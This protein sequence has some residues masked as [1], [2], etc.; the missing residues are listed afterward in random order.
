[1]STGEFMVNPA[2]RYVRRAA[3]LAGGAGL[4]DGQLLARFIAHRD[5]AAFEMLVRRHG[6]MV[7]GVCRRILR[8]GPDTDDAFQATFLVL[9]RKAAAIADRAKL[10]NW[11]YG[12]A[13]RTA[14]KARALALRRRSREVPMANL[15]DA[16]AATPE[17]GWADWLPVLDRELA[18]LP[19]KYRIA[20]VLCDLEGRTQKAA[21][22]Q[23]G[24]PEGTVSSRLS[25]ARAMLAARLTRYK[26]PITAGLLAAAL[27]EVAATRVRAALVGTTVRSAVAVAGGSAATGVMISAQV[28]ALTEGVMKAMLLSKLKIAIGAPVAMILGIAI[29][30]VGADVVRGGRPGAV[31]APAPAA[32]PA[33]AAS[34]QVRWEYKTVTR[35]ELEDLAPEDAKDRLLSGL[36]ALGDEGWELTAIDTSAGAVARQIKFAGGG[37]GF[38]GA[39]AQPGA[40]APGNAGGP[41]GAVVNPIGNGAM[42]T[43]NPAHGTYLFKRPK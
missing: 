2:V 28:T 20:V 25:R 35:K 29:L 11:L 19:D 17:T 33:A 14:Q 43:V 7:I 6:P 42:F 13:C 41:P 24:W 22:K 27:A 5:E 9:A 40:A 31:G 12:V 10:A 21:A 36:N 23:L 34:P 37:G 1:M 8:N 15:P 3:L 38:G 16:P 4:A 32:A 39:G 26:A 30:G 18:R